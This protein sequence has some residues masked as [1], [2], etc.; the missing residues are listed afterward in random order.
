MPTD[1]D[2]W[3]AVEQGKAS[4]RG[5][6]P[7]W[8]DAQRRAM[9]TVTLSMEELERGDVWAVYGHHL[10]G[11]I[12]ADEAAKTQ[13]HAEIDTGA[14]VGD[15]LARAQLRLQRLVG[16]IEARREDQALP[17]ELITRYTQIETALSDAASKTKD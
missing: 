11:L 10:D 12:A 17:R 14:L 4:A 3:L 6:S 15:D 1:F 5:P 7:G 13:L 2:Q 9:H 8:L 16:R